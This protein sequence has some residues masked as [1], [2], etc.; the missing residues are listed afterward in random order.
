MVEECRYDDFI[1]YVSYDPIEE[2]YFSGVPG[3]VVPTIFVGSTEEEVRE[4][5]EQIL[6]NPLNFSNED[7]FEEREVSY[8][9]EEAYCSGWIIRESGTNTRNRSHRKQ[10]LRHVE[11]ERI[12]SILSHVKEDPTV[13]AD[14][15]LLLSEWNEIEQREADFA[16]ERQEARMR[17]IYMAE[18]L[19][20]PLCRSDD[21]EIMKVNRLG[22]QK[23]TY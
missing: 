18:D 12:K 16:E 17:L 7:D 1:F 8:D 13:S 22:I 4:S 15:D 10:I 3:F 19:G 20:H 11:N 9:A 21:I 5:V 6:G 14:H 2:H 23:T